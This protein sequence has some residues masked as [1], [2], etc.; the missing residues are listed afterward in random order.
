MLLFQ[1]GSHDNTLMRFLKR[2]PENTAEGREQRR[3]KTLKTTVPR[4]SSA[5]HVG[6]RHRGIK[7]H[8]FCLLLVAT[9]F[10]LSISLFCF[11]AEWTKRK[12]ETVCLLLC[13]FVPLRNETFGST[14]MFFYTTTPSPPTVNFIFNLD[15]W[16]LFCINGHYSFTHFPCVFL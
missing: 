9:F 1:S 3:Q 11:Y 8:C 4:L 12:Y 16:I 5:A 7:Q 2:W 10:P 6:S 15:R 13:F 14:A